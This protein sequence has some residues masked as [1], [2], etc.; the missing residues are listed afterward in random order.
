MKQTGKQS[1][2]QPIPL[3]SARLGQDSDGDGEG[4]FPYLDGIRHNCGLPI[5]FVL[6]SQSFCP[7][8]DARWCI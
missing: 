5:N 7:C 1:S 2:P 8:A 3:G 6:V 4:T